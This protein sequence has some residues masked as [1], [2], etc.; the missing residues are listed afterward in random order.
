MEI[1][2]LPTAEEASEVAARLSFGWRYL[3]GHWVRFP[4]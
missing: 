2:I 3:N 4:S 1:I